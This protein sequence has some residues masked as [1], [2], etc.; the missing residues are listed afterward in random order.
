MKLLHI[1]KQ[2][3]KQAADIINKM[4]AGEK[5]FTSID[6]EYWAIKKKEYEEEYIEV[7]TALF[8]Y[9]NQVPN[10]E[11]REFINVKHI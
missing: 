6:P 2:L 11:H 9:L 8:Y 1:Q 10:V 3:I 7:V 5:F 4:E